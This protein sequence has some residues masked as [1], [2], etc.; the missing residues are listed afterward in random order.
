[1]GGL[2]G[3]IISVPI[4]VIV[5]VIGGF[6]DAFMGATL[7]EYTRQRQSGIAAKAGWRAVLSRAAVAAVKMGIGVVMVVGA[8]FITLRK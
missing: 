6:V 5:S 7:F 1:M 4:P 2:V 3:A 8:L